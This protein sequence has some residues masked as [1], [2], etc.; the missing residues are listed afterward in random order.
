[1][2]TSVSSALQSLSILCL[3]SKEHQGYTD[4][5]FL[6]ACVVFT[7]VFADVVWTE[8]SSL[9][10]TDRETIIVACGKAIRDTIFMATGR[11][12]HDIAKGAEGATPKP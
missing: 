11:D 10:Q 5:D 4:R 1:M 2:R 6:N 3:D 7:H 8:N 12:M 9:P